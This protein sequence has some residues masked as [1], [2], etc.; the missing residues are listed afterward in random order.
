MAAASKIFFCH[1]SCLLN[2]CLLKR[3]SRIVGSFA[4]DGDVVRMALGAAGIGDADELGLLQ[5]LDGAAAR[6]AHAG[7]QAA[8]HLVEH[9][10]EGAFV[11]HAA[12]NAF[13]HKLLGVGLLVLEVAVL[14]A[15]LHG[16]ERAHAAVGL[17]LAAFEDDGLAGSL[18]GAGHQAAHHDGAGACGE[19]LDDVAAVADAAVGDDGHVVAVLLQGAAHLAHSRELRHADTGDDA[20]GADAS[21]SDA[22]LDGVGAGLGQ[23]QG[24]LAGGD[25]AHH[26]VDVLILGF[27]LL[28]GFH[29]A[30]AVAVGGVDDDGVG[31][32]L[33]QGVDTVHHVGRDA[34]TGGHAQTAVAVLAGV[35]TLLGLHDVAV[36]DEA[37]ELA[38][39]VHHGQLLDLVLLQD[40]GSLGKGGAHMGGDE[41]GDH[42]LAQRALHVALEAQVAVGHHADEHA[43]L[44]HDGDAADA[45]L[46]H[47]VQGVLHL[48]ILVEG[49]GVDNHAVLGTFHLAHL[50]GLTLDAHVLVQHADAALL[51]HADGHGGLGD[52]VHCRADQRGV[53]R[54]VFRK[55]GSNRNLAG[56]DFGVSGDEQHVVVSEAFA[57][58]F[59]G[60]CKH[61]L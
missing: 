30:D 15:A 35:G 25:V 58:E 34:H 2:Y 37:H 51:G 56:E 4:G 16:L 54:D 55:T 20:G 29:H 61:D 21:G 8:N 19:G 50:V 3:L 49:H 39:L 31:A 28:E 11:G 45:V 24:G 38:L 23:H 33:H 26:H 59:G 47:Q 32:G 6:V 48:G 7:L 12:H 17:E 53:Q 1:L 57:D 43:V 10:A 13:G 9:F 5:V 46:L 60:V 44:V 52:G 41:L 40:V 22:H 42:D 18:V 14:R 27:H 36:G